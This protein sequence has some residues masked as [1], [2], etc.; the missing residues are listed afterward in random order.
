MGKHYASDTYD[1][2][3]DVW[4]GV[5]EAYRCIRQRKAA[6]GPGWI[7]GGD[8]ATNTKIFIERGN[9]R[10]EWLTVHPNGRIEHHVETKGHAFL[11]H[12]PQARDQWV[13]LEHV[14]NYWPEILPQVEAALA[15]LGAL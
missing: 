11:R 8:T 6:G 4:T 10:E 1:A 3:R 9:S 5:D 14:R 15:E 13:E 12:G 2:T 7:A